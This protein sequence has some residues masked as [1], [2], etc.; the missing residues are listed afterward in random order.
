MLSCLEEREACSVNDNKWTVPL[1][2]SCRLVFFRYFAVFL[3]QPT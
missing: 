3:M 2:V 1:T